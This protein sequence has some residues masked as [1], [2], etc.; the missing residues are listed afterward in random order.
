M[1]RVDELRA[2]VTAAEAQLQQLRA[3]LAEAEALEKDAEHPANWNWPL[4]E[5]EY[6]RYGRQ[7]IIPTV[8]IKGNAPLTTSSLEHMADHA[9]AS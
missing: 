3:E 6:E 8:G 5:G 4:S 9:Q 7:L 1:G 2:K